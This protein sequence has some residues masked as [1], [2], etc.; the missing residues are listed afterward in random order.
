MKSIALMCVAL[1]AGGCVAFQPAPLNRA[2]A[3]PA[4]VPARLVS[5][6]DLV[7]PGEP[8][9]GFGGPGW[10]RLADNLTAK[11]WSAALKLDLEQSFKP[12]GTGEILD[13]WILDGGLWWEKT[14]AD[15]IP[16]VN[17]F[18]TNSSLGKMKCAATLTVRSG[19]RSNRVAVENIVPHTTD[20]VQAGQSIY[21]LSIQAC[22]PGLVQKVVNVIRAEVPK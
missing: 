6:V 15:M 11:P 5:V 13:I 7:K 17:L 21:H 14:G 9:H 1:V 22:Y 3:A 20:G 18:T 16:I 8:E 2:A 12:S 4:E 19:A 10:Y